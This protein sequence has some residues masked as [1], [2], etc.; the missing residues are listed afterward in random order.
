MLSS[1]E[2]V[3]AHLIT[4]SVF[5]VVKYWNLYHAFG[6]NAKSNLEEVNEDIWQV[7]YTSHGVPRIERNITINR[8]LLCVL[9]E[10]STCSAVRCPSRALN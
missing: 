5:S 6:H 4:R 9:C 10:Y 1:F 8:N 2:H 7:K 3:G